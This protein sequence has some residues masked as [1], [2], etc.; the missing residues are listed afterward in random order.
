MSVFIIFRIIVQQIPEYS[1]E[2][3]K[4]QWHIDSKHNE[5]MQIASKVVRIDTNIFNK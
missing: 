1:N 4:V 2:V 3:S 5:E